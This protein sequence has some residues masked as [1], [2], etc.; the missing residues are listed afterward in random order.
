LEG[1]LEAILQ[2][3]QTLIRSSQTDHEGFYLLETIDET[4]PLQTFERY[5]VPIFSL[6]FGRLTAG[7]TVKFV[8]SFLVFFSLFIAKH[9]GLCVVGAVNGM[10]NNMFAMIIESLLFPYILKVDGKIERKLCEIAISNLLTQTPAFLQEPLMNLWPALMDTVIKLFEALDTTVSRQDA[11]MEHYSAEGVEFATTSF[12]V[13]VFAHKDTIDPFPNVDPKR[14]LVESL[15][16]M[17]PPTPGLIAGLFQRTTPDTQTFLF[18]YARAY[19]I[20]EPLF[21]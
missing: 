17:S 5:L 9:G 16:R 3:F 10:Q 1:N 4:I 19:G 13:L 20:G 8:R 11:T 7:K 14:L 21:A 2:V 6:I 12:A 15:K 18:A